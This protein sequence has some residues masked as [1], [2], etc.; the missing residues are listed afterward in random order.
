[1]A[2]LS[3]IQVI[4]EVKDSVQNP[5]PLPWSLGR[6]NRVGEWGRQGDIYVTL[7]DPPTQRLEKVD[8]FTGQVVEGNTQGSRHCVDN[9]NAVVAYNNPDMSLSK[10]MILQVKEACSIVHP[11]HGSVNLDGGIWVEIGHQINE[12]N[13]QKA[14]SKD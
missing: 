2:T 8:K 10:G 7:I 4:R 11:E 5:K 14:R 6:A 1:M 3:A 13:R 9:P 12:F